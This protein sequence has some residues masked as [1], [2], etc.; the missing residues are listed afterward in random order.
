MKRT[1]LIVLSV[2]ALLSPARLS[3]QNWSTTGGSSMRNGISASFGPET[4]TTPAWTKTDASPS[5]WGNAIFTNHDRFATSRVTFTPSYS[6]SVEC[7][8]LSDGS[9][10]WEKEFPDEAKLYVVGMTDDAVYVHNYATDSLF[11]LYPGTGEIRWVCPEKA[12][13][14][15]GAHGILFACNGDPVVN[16]PDMYQKSL[17]R[18]DKNT[19]QVKW[20]NTNFVSVGPAT[21]FCISGDRLYK[22]EGAIGIP[23]HLVAIDLN[24]GDN[25][26]YSEEIGGDPDQEIPLTAGPDGTI[27][28]QRDGGDLWAITDEG[29]SFS[30]KWFYSPESG[31]MGT[32]GNIGTGPD[33]SVYFPDGNVVKR[34]D[35]ADGSL[36]N[37]SEPLSADPMWGTFIVTDRDGTVYISNTEA[38]GGKY[39][40]FAPDL[41]TK[42]WEKPVP[43]NYYAAP[44]ISRDGLFIMAGA[45]TSISGYKTGL[46]HPPVSWFI[47]DTTRITEGESVSFTDLSSF[48]PASWEWT[49][50]GGIPS[51]STGQDPGTVV[52]NS[53]GTY[54]VTLVTANANGSDTLVRNCYIQV[55]PV[56]FISRPDELTGLTVSPNPSDGLFTLRAKDKLPR[57]T[58]IIITDLHGRIVYESTVAMEGMSIDLRGTVSRGI[59]YIQCITDRTSFAGKLVIR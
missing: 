16:G 36:L 1:S 40:A 34:L 10:L 19:G 29:T 25:L 5:L 47:A 28:G 7:R 15:G 11:S 27:Y 41:Q 12:M 42:N 55:D 8:S 21:D 56:S 49:F 9:L 14:F 50:E 44:Q 45:G 52:Y 37:T 22:W 53:A 57:T 43:Y 3:S 38:S 26:F 51:S 6:V 23:T 17:M 4:V 35:P 33:G 20:F 2:I 18:L 59:Y 39:Y 46:P 54:P 13:I 32:Y 58:R 31:G 48:G 24:T 30:V